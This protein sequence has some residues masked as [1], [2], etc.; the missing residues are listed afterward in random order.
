M[1]DHRQQKIRFLVMINW[2]FL[3][4]DTSNDFV[5]TLGAAVVM[6]YVLCHHVF[7][8]FC[9]YEVEA[10]AQ[11]QIQLEPNFCLSVQIRTLRTLK[12]LELSESTSVSSLNLHFVA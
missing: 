8:S 11:L 2:D 10:V 5:F 12:S 6:F 4:W 1:L 3:R 9:C 7:K